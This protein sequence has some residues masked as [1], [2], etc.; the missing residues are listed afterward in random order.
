VN[1]GRLERS[2]AWPG[3]SPTLPRPHARAYQPFEADELVDVTEQTVADPEGAIISTTRDVNRFFRALLSGRLLQ[4]AQLAETKRAIGVSP[5]FEQLMP[6]ARY[7]LGLFQR[8]LPCGGTYWSHPGGGSG[9]V[10][11]NGI[12]ADGRR[13]VVL[14]MSSVLGHSPDDF[15]RQQ[16]AADTLVDHALCGRP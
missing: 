15:L 2:S 13:S 5:E 7:G 3:R 6:G 10:T 12:T 9:Y 8:P 11:D 16:R 1:T 4:P 14:S